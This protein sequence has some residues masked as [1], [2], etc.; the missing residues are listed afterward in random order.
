MIR[1]VYTAKFKPGVTAEQAA[2]WYEA[3][4]HLEIAG[5]Q[6]FMGGPDLGLREGNADYALV[7]DLEDESAFRRYDEDE[8][9][10]RIRREMA[11]PIVE[12]GDRCQIEVD[13][14]YRPAPIRNV[15]LIWYKP[16]TDAAVM[17]EVATRTRALAIDGME[18]LWAGRDLG[19]RPGNADAAV[20]ADF[21]DADGYR[22]YDADEE[23]NR[24]RREL[25]API[26]ERVVRV[27]FG[28][29]T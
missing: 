8:L 10:N 11:A 9:H 29:P 24:I 3:L 27:Q 4:T 2:R 7:A 6:R 13:P 22:R 20:V 21:H 23:H 19:L 12:Q 25:L 1:H 5:M 28:V 14:G 15:T 26:V 17:D 18:A 16:G